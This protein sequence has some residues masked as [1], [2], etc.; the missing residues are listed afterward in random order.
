MG[1]ADPITMTHPK[2][3][4]DRI[5]RMARLASFVLLT[6][7][8]IPAVRQTL[9]RIG[10]PGLALSLLIGLSLLGF[11]VYRLIRCADRIKAADQNPFTAS[12]D[13]TDVAW[14]QDESGA[15]LELCGPALRRRYPWRH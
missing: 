12:A 13:D 1:R 10:F 2:P 7:L 14:R 11:G 9:A 5:G 15:N 3:G 8:L 4:T 6:S